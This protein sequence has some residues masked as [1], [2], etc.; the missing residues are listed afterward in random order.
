MQAALA[1]VVF[2]FGF[3]LNRFAQC[4]FEHC[5]RVFPLFAAAHA[6]YEYQ[7]GLG[8]VGGHRVDDVDV[9]GRIAAYARFVFAADKADDGLRFAVADDGGAGL[10][11][12]HVGRCRICAVLFEKRVF[13][14]FGAA[15]DGGNAV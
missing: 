10:R 1:Q 12:K 15:Q 6:G 4:L 13:G 8:G 2:R 5:I 11:V 7:A 3:G 9:A 14:L